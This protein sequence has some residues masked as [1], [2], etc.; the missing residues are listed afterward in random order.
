MLGKL[1]E[2]ELF[3]YLKV[4]TDHLHVF[5]HSHTQVVPLFFFS[6]LNNKKKRQFCLHRRFIH[7]HPLACQLSIH[8]G[9]KRVTATV[10][11]QTKRA[12]TICL[13]PR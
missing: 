4:S 1:F 13:G 11:R 5:A 6:S 8:Q 7:D 9:T 12:Q 2:R 3:K 10:P